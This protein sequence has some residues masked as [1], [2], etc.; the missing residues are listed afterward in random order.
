[1]YVIP[2]IILYVLCKCLNKHQVVILGTENVES[3]F[4]QKKCSMMESLIINRS[5]GNA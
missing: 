1:M 5:V 4:F 3:T 2:Y